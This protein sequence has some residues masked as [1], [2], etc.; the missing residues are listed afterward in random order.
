MDYKFETLKVSVPSEYIYHI[1]FTRTKKLNT[2]TIQF[3]SDLLTCFSQIGRDSNVRCVILSAQMESRLFTAG[4]DLKS[5]Q[6]LPTPDSEVDAA[7]QGIKFLEMVGLFQDA[8][9]AI[10]KCSKPVIAGSSF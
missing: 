2:L 8:I 1:E 4:L 10:E 5:V 3:F 9:T 7:R 6:G